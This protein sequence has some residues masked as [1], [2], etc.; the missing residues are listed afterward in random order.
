MRTP[1][2]ALGLAIHAALL[3]GLLD[4]DNN[5][6]GALILSSTLRCTDADAASRLFG[7]VGT[8]VWEAGGFAP[9]IRELPRGQLV[10]SNW[11]SNSVVP[12]EEDGQ[13]SG[14]VAFCY[15]RVDRSGGGMMTPIYLALRSSFDDDN[16]EMGGSVRWSRSRTAETT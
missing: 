12:A 4:E 6:E 7:G 14:F 16:D 3:A 13:R 9:P 10:P 5:D 8:T 1:L 11:E 2:G 15:Y